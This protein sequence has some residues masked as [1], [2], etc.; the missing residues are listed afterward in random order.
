MSMHGEEGATI[1]DL[2]EELPMQ[3]P[4]L[5]EKSRR[6]DEVWRKG[7]VQSGLDSWFG[8]IWSLSNSNLVEPK[9]IVNLIELKI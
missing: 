5:C 3:N 9:E 1:S 6:V 4:Y 8:S 2:C 7:G